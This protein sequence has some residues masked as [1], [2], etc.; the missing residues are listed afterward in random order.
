MSQDHRR[1]DKL[2]P[3]FKGPYEILET[4]PNDRYSLRGHNNLRN[5][6]VAKEKLRI[7]PGEWIDQNASVEESL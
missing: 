3:K 2:I 5:I 7:Y 4:L 1:H 6:I